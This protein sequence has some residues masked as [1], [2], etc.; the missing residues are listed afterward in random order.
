MICPYPA[1]PSATTSCGITYRYRAAKRLW[2][3][4]WERHPRRHT[5]WT[6]EADLTIS[7]AISLKSEVPICPLGLLVIEFSQSFVRS[8]RAEDILVAIR[9]DVNS[10]VQIALRSSSSRQPIHLTSFK[11]TMSAA[12]PQF[13]KF[14]DE[15]QE[16]FIQRLAEAVAI[17]S[18]VLSS[19]SI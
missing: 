17:P 9:Q 11:H 16:S 1:F 13:L 5:R 19:S 6:D 14:I 8:F 18:Y 12:N 4:T 10:L 7:L 15:N 3:E 2:E